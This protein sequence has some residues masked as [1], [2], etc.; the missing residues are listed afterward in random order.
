LWDIDH[1]VPVSFFYKLIKANEDKLNCNQIK[2]IITVSESLINL[3]PLYKKENISKSDKIIPEF[4]KELYESIKD[5]VGFE[6]D[7]LRD[8]L[9]EKI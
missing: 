7:L 2:N 4:A 8:K 6:Y 1:K 5:K 9:K 3:R